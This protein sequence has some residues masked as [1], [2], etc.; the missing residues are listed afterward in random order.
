MLHYY[1]QSFKFSSSVISPNGICPHF[2][3]S[4]AANVSRSWLT[5]TVAADC[6]MDVEYVVN[7]GGASR[8]SRLALYRFGHVVFA[9]GPLPRGLRSELKVPWRIVGV[10]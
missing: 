2:Q 6:T 8:P 4:A 10:L 5:V 1:V 9:R 7:G 3:A